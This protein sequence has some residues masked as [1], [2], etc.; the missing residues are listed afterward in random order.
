MHAYMYASTLLENGVFSRVY[1]EHS[2]SIRSMQTQGG[3]VETL[4][5]KCSSIELCIHLNKTGVAGET[6]SLHLVTLN[7]QNS[8]EILPR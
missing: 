8:C 7:N 5:H 2:Y 1:K 3:S 6:W 4:G